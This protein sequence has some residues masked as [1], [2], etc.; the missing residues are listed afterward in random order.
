MMLKYKDQSLKMEMKI[1]EEMGG[2]PEE[3]KESGRSRGQGRGESK[4]VSTALYY[5]VYL[6]KTSYSLFFIWKKVLSLI[7]IAMGQWSFILSLVLF[8]VKC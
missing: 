7:L 1:E 4:K 3:E 6:F 8:L 5:M 2:E